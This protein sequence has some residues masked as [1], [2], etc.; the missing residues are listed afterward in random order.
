MSSINS[1]K[2][3]ISNGNTP[4]NLPK[5]HLAGK[6]WKQIYIL[7]TFF[8]MFI[9]AVLLLDIIN[10]SFGY[11]ALSEKVKVETLSSSGIP[12]EMMSKPQLI[13]ILNEN[14]SKNRVKT[15]EKTKP[16][17]ELSEEELITIVVEEVENLR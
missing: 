1:F 11:I 13:S 7:S 4:S 16:L 9:L 10:D 14:L 3:Q 8:G 15:L 2:E 12:L 6:I 17:D 5:R